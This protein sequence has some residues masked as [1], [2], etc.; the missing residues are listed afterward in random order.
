MCYSA[1]HLNESRPHDQERTLWITYY[2]TLSVIGGATVED[3][4]PWMLPLA[5]A[6]QIPESVSLAGKRVCAYLYTQSPIM[7]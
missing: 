4:D 5:P 1:L 3:S 6:L 2:N 7:R